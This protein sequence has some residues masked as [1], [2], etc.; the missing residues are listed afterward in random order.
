MTIE[1]YVTHSLFTATFLEIRRQRM[2]P[3]FTRML[4]TEAGLA[5]TAVVGLI[6]GIAYGIFYPFACMDHYFGDEAHQT[7]IEQRVITPI[8][9]GTRQNIAMAIISLAGIVTCPLFPSDPEHIRTTYL[10]IL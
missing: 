8:L 5:L 7:D 4:V 3:S 6:E 1:S 9:E 10:P 2:E